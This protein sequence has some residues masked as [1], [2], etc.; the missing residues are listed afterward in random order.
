MRITEIVLRRLRLPLRKPYRRSYRVDHT[1]DPLLVEV[2]DAAGRVG[3]GNAVIVPGYTHET[4][5]ESLRLLA[6]I[7]PSLIGSTPSR[8][9]Q[10]LLGSFDTIPNGVTCAVAA[11]EMLERSVLLQVAE[12]RR[13]P[14]LQGLSAQTAD[15][16]PA[17][18]RSIIE[19]GF[20]TIKVKVGFD[21]DADLALVRAVQAAAA[22]RATI[23]LDANRGFTREQGCRFGAALDPAGI[24][25]FEQPCE[26]HDWP[27]NAAV[28]AVST[29]P[30]MLD[31]SI[32]SAADI[33]RAA[34]IDGIRFVKLKLKK[35]GSLSRLH[36]WLLRIREL[37]MVPVLGD[38][39]ATDLDCWMESC[40]AG[41]TIEN[42]GEM[43]GF[44]RLQ[45][46]LF[47][48]PLPFEDGSV[49]LPAGYW[50]ELDT[51][52]VEDTTRAV[53]RYVSR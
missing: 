9:A 20:T 27:S 4:P 29:V 41:T 31:E 16:A 43:N 17:E 6:Q 42:A 32:Y 2:H 3:W 40:I 8:A 22:G 26:S 33:E 38:G 34:A 14:L 18:A 24:E 11:L 53:E 30:V 15:D 51:D 28:A 52:T 48:N 45:R 5:E 50:P 36:E 25:L 37:G 46:G 1:F 19:A 12:D 39:V 47:R 44:L 21:V 49:R 10:Q 23:R 13:V 7:L 35:A